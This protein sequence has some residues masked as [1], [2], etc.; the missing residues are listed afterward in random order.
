MSTHFAGNKDRVL[1][2]GSK[3]I[4]QLIAQQFDRASFT[5]HIQ[6]K[7]PSFTDPD[8]IATL[9]SIFSKFANEAV[10]DHHNVHDNVHHYVPRYIHRYIHPGVTTWAE[11]PELISV[12]QEFGLNVLAPSSQVL[13]SFWNKLSFLHDAEA[14]GIPNLVMSFDPLHTVR[15]IELAFVSKIKNSYP[16]ILRSATGGGN[17]A[18]RVVSGWDDLING[19]P[20]WRDQLLINLGEAIVFGQRYLDGARQI[21]VPFAGFMNGKAQVFPFVDV[22]LQSRH[23]KI[24]EFCP[25]SQIDPPALKLLHEY[26]LKLIDKYHFVG[27][28]YFEFMV[29]GSRVYL[30]DGTAR[31]NTGFPIW[32][33]AAGV[34]IATWQLAASERSLPADFPCRKHDEETVFNLA[35][36][37]CAEDSLLQLPHPGIIHELSEIREWH[38]PA[39]HAELHLNYEEGNE[40][41]HNDTGFLGMLFIESKTQK[42]AFSAA[43]GII[44]ETWI[45]GSVQTNERFL[46]ELLDHPWVSAGIFHSRFTDEE[47]IPTI[48]PST[49]VLKMFSSICSLMCQDK[50]LKK[51]LRWVVGD[52]WIKPGHEEISWLKEPFYWTLDSPSGG[53]PGLS[54]TI[55]LPDGRH[56]KVCAFPMV[57]KK[58]SVRLGN[59]F[60][61]VRA[62]APKSKTNKAEPKSKPMALAMAP[63]VIHS[64]R[65]REGSIIP[66]HEPF[67]I[68]KSLGYLVPHAFPLDARLIKLTVHPEDTVS[69]GQELAEVELVEN[70]R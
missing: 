46:Q 20:I 7:L 56:T 51:D 53:L 23:K 33:R 57:D 68:I 48:R 27:I 8:R 2:L 41:Q 24:M 13:S 28:G 3:A 5:T 61:L 17:F 15:E 62:V 1:V 25:V 4:S 11:R 29:D 16:F 58:W 31:L 59:W 40:I 6:E 35:L 22:S 63:G 52:Q 30:A 44:N 69:A 64:I 67:L 47:F 19:V 37:L 43:K 42:Q 26:T 49:E 70:G 10:A 55:K 38:S 66:A 36:R 32:A 21:L 65:V 12:A 14:I 54:G 34:D 9:R 18:S 39:T 60:F 45:A 50:D